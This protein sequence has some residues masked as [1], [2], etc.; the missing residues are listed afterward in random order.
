MA[1]SSKRANIE[2]TTLDFG[3]VAAQADAELTMAVN[4]VFN[5]G[6]EIVVVSAPVLEAGLVASGYVSDVD[7][8]TI[9]LSNVTA[10]PIDPDL[11]DFNI[12]VIQ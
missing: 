12:A 10:A 2:S 9:R 7:E 6:D 1:R 8:V 4:G 11:Q 5:N 3:T